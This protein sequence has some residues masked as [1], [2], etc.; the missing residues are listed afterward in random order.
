M[1]FWA[2][3]AAL[4]FREISPW[5]VCFTD[6]NKGGIFDW[7][8]KQRHTTIHRLELRKEEVPP[9]H[10]FV[11]IY[12]D[13][14]LV[15]RVE[16]KASRGLNPNA[17][18]HCGCEAEDTIKPVNANELR[19]IQDKTNARIVLTFDAR[20]PDIYVVIAVCVALQ[21]DPQTRR[22]TMHYHNCFF[23]AR[24]I[25]TIVIRHCLL[26]LS[27]ML[28]TATDGVRWDLATT[29]TPSK[30]LSRGDWGTLYALVETAATTA[31]E[32]ALRPIIL[33]E[34]P[35]DLLQ[36]TMPTVI[37]DA[38]RDVLKGFIGN[39]TLYALYCEVLAAAE[40]TL[41]QNNL[42]QNLSATM[43]TGQCERVAGG[44]LYA[45]G[46]AHGERKGILDEILARLGGIFLP[47]PF[48]K[49][50]PSFFPGATTRQMARVPIT[51]QHT[52]TGP[53][54]TPVD[55][56]QKVS[57]RGPAALAKISHE[58]LAHTP[59]TL[60]RKAVKLTE[61]IPQS[62]KDSIPPELTRKIAPEL[63]ERLTSIRADILR[64]KIQETL[65]SW[66]LKGEIAENIVNKLL[67]QVDAEIPPSVLGIL[68]EG[69]K[70]Q[71]LRSHTAVQNY[72]LVMT[73]KHT[74]LVAD[75]AQL[76][77]GEE[78]VYDNIRNKTEQIW[79]VVRMHQG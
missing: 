70:V 15:Y 76:T 20:K 48:S 22:Y 50:P 14:G 30:H 79:R 73:R 29:P 21:M 58:L 38:V 18:A 43:H 19:S 35:V 5:R 78:A 63:L 13:E 51:Q 72:I 59:D 44:I 77:M 74:K 49:T 25:V 31:L 66:V 64:E 47:R 34:L 4:I 57:M 52:D 33:S 68:I 23:L 28:S 11:L 40:Q 10:E 12:L 32:R 55:S 24:A 36:Q 9:K 7:Y 75:V 17:I 61:K 42:K 2:S 53:A 62:I 27:P 60:L 67:L 41:W 1:A 8:R 37:R 26:Q 16:R 65:A 71:Q 46:K 3:S 45:L 69:E 54:R 39:G 56:F 6:W